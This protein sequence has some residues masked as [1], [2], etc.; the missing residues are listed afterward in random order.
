MPKTLVVLLPLALFGCRSAGNSEDSGD[1]WTSVDDTGSSSDSA[2]NT[3][4]DT[5]KG[6]G[7]KDTG[8]GGGSKDTGKGGGSYGATGY[9]FPESQTGEL[10]ASFEHEGEDCTVSYTASDFTA[11]TDCTD[12]S[13]A[14]SFLLK[15]AAVVSGD[16]SCMDEGVG[17]DG[18]VP[19]WGQGTEVVSE[20]SGISYHDLLQKKSGT[21]YAM[22]YGFSWVE[23]K[24]G[25]DAWGVYM[26][27]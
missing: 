22:G 11:L 16:S 12:C 25:S 6:G 15:A 13:F 4:K 2:A 21:W 27:Y 7:G 14:W 26:A 18:Q 8:K 24:S 1:W 9:L 17:Y 19:E 20:K 5:G 23:D 10:T 3:N